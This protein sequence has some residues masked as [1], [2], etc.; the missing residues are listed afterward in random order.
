MGQSGPYF[1]QKQGYK[2][3]MHFEE[4]GTRRGTE[5]TEDRL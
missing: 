5:N 3:E 2:D 4:V 1:T